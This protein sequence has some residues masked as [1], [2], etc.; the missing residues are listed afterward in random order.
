MWR[1]VDL[2]PTVVLEELQ[3]PAHA[4]SLL[5]DF[6]TLKM[7]AISSSEKSVCTRSRGATSQKEAF[8]IVTAV[9]TSNLTNRILSSSVL[10]LK[11]VSILLQIKLYDTRCAQETYTY[12]SNM[13]FY[14]LYMLLLVGLKVLQFRNLSS[15]LILPITDGLTD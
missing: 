1:R 9:K 8:F 10:L 5:A 14:S 2:V 4:G 12:S 11:I 15:G 6:Y 3:P 7:K 13:L